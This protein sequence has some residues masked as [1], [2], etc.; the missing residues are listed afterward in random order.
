MDDVIECFLSHRIFELLFHF[1][2]LYRFLPKF[3]QNHIKISSKLTRVEAERI[4]Q[5]NFKH[6]NHMLAEKL[7]CWLGELI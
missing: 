5:I 3:E 7:T 4:E 1:Y 2:Y 6:K